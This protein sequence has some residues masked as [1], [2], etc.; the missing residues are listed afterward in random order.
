MVESDYLKD[1][2][3]IIQKLRQIPNLGLFDDEQLH[4]ILQLSKIRKYEKGELILEENKYDRWIYFLVSGKVKIVKGGEELRV[5]DRGGDLFGEVGAVDG[6]P[7]SAS[8]YAVDQAVCLATDASHVD[9]LSG[10]DKVAFSCI[11]YQVFA[12]VLANRLRSTS[13]DLIKAMEEIARLRAE[14]NG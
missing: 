13:E 7:R 1:N 6:L 2:R 8:A 4:G 9:R 12:Q 5:L 11:L 10:N 14:L 3:E